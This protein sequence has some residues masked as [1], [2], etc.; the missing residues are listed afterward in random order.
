VVFHYPDRVGGVKCFD[1]NKQCPICQGS[2]IARGYFGGVKC[3]ICDGTGNIIDHGRRSR[4][5][6]QISESSKEVLS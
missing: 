3:L 2:G 1:R 4:T 6:L 5:T